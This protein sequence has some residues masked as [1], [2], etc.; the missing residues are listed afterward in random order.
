MCVRLCVPNKNKKDEEEKEL[1]PE[2][3]YTEH[4]VKLSRMAWC[5][6]RW[7]P[8]REGKGSLGEKRKR[9]WVNISI[10][11]FYVNSRYIFSW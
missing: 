2:S 10:N 1:R 9:A 7:L 6:E 3:S 4:H 11:V 8:L 5:S